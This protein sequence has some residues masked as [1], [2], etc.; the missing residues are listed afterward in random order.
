MA[1]TDVLLYEVQAVPNLVKNNKFAFIPKAVLDK[2]RSKKG[3]QLLG[4]SGKECS[5]AELLALPLEKC[6]ESR[7]SA[8]GKCGL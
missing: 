7:S 1:A 2:N 4:K 6:L 3:E 5:E 8:G